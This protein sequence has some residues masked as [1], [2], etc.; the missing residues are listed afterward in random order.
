MER[1]NGME[2]EET[3]G[4]F[5]LVWDEHCFPLGMDSMLLADF[6]TLRKRDRVADLG[7]GAGV[8][9]LLLF[10][11][12][13]ELRADGVELSPEAAGQARGNLDRNGLSARA[14]ILEGDLRSPSVPLS[15]GAY[16][17]AVSNPP[18]FSPGSGQTAGTKARAA[19]RSELFCPAE[20]LCRAAARLLRP[21]GRFALVFRPERLPALF[22]A[23]EGA[24]L[25]PKRLRFV[26]HQA[27]KPPSAVLA[28][29]VR[30]G[31]PGLACLP[32]LLVREENGTESAEIKRIYHQN[33]TAPAN[34]PGA[35]G[36][37]D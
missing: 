26:H 30:G 28:E 1:R 16:D 32:P 13:P 29:A 3:L 7:C 18:Y 34:A 11:R 6:A 17:L 8:L 12:E 22:S 5:R 20:E 19:A 27:N 25:E 33:P 23:L 31:K 21:G 2:R 24:G 35:G 15:P 9:L 4:G 14:R 37:E 36:Q 10:S